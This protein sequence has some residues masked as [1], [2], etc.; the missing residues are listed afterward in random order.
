MLASLQINDKTESI[1]QVF[2]LNEQEILATQEMELS[3]FYNHQN[4]KIIPPQKIPSNSNE[5]VKNSKSNT[6]NKFEKNEKQ[7]TFGDVKDKE[8]NMSNTLKKEQL[9]LGIITKEEHEQKDKEREG[10]KEKDTVSLTFKDFPVETYTEINT[11]QVDQEKNKKE[12]VKE[13]EPIEVSNQVKTS[14]NT[15]NPIVEKKE[16]R[17]KQEISE[18]SQEVRKEVIPHEVNESYSIKPEKVRYLLN[19]R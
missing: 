6:N 9:I 18:V 15:K 12:R 7:N 16:E 10:E 14:I 5:I 1:S 2:Q 19:L 4:N 11:K 17:N 8:I 3:P 13:S